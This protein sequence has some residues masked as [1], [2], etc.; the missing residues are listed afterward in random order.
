MGQIK[1]SSAKGIHITFDNGYTLSV[2]FGPGNYCDHYDRRIGA[3]DAACGK[4]GSSTAETAYWSDDGGLINEGDGDT[5]QGYQTIDQ[6]ID[7][8]NRV[9]ALPKKGAL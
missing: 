7:R 5:V 6:V 1:L 3:D 8:I 2:Q 4:E 9:R